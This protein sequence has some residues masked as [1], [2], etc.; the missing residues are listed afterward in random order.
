MLV[1][2]IKLLL[3]GPAV[4][5]AVIVIKMLV[6]TY[7]I[8]SLIGYC[9]IDMIDA[10]RAE[11]VKVGR[12]I[13]DKLLEKG[14]LLVYENNNLKKRMKTAG[15]NEE[16]D[17]YGY[18]IVK[19]AMSVKK[20]PEIEWVEIL[21]LEI[22]DF[23]FVDLSKKNREIKQLYNDLQWFKKRVDYHAKMTKRYA[24]L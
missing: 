19:V 10:L 24:K 11:P 13:F 23:Y 2:Y 20:F 1:L 6:A 7:R 15:I 18:E 22:I 21:N 14:N 17:D 8:H 16:A 5:M 12:M 9:G 4:I 3:L